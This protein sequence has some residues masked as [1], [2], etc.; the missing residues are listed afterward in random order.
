MKQGQ[1]FAHICGC[2]IIETNLVLTAG[3]CLKDKS[4][5]ELRIVFGTGDLSHA[6]SLQTTRKISKIV[7]HPL[8]QGE[9]YYDVAVAVLDEELE[10]NEAIAK[11]CLPTEATIDARHRFGRF[12]TLTGWGA[13]QPGEGATSELRQASMMIFATSYCNKTRTTVNN[14][15]IESDSILVP[16][17]F[18]SSVICAGL[19]NYPKSNLDA[20]SDK[21]F[22]FQVIKAE[23]QVLHVEETLE[24]L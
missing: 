16:N 24:V 5:S 18:L 1:G 12:T 11:V 20:L 17:L 10:F 3:H 22:N 2:S 7:I 13:T 8:Y 14:Q 4:V 15:N 19:T 23:L 21:N 6:G 9:S